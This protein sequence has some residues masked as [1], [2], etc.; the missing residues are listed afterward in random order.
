MPPNGCRRCTRWASTWS[1]WRP[2][3]RLATPSARARTTRWGR[4]R[5]T[6]AARGRLA[7]RPAATWRSSRRSARSTISIASWRRRR[8]WT[9]TSRS[10]SPS[11]ARP[12]T[13]GCTEHP[14]WFYQRADGTIRYAENPPK[15]YED[16]YPVNFDTA[17]LA[18]AVGRAARGGALL[19][20]ARRQGVPGGQPA[21]Q[22]H[23]LLGLAHRV[24]AAR[25]AGGHL[26][27]R[28]VHPPADDAGARPSAASRSRTPT[29]RGATPRPSSPST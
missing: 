21:H 25:V 6:P 15:K 28:G 16:I 23:R 24:G 5:T 14:E 1:T 19:G 29:S 7:A 2:S 26:P 3:I 10:T 8:R 17:G 11:S 13:R 12:I 9:W 4:A 22:A 27:G 18:G 20:G